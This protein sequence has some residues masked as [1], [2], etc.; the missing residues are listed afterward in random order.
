MADHGMIRAFESAS[1]RRP[2]RSFRIGVPVDQL[3]EV[4]I[5]DPS[6]LFPPG[7]RASGILL[8]ITSLP[9]RFGIGDFGPE[10]TRWIDSLALG[11]QSWWQ[12]LPIGPTSCGNSPYTP[13]STFAC[14]PLLISPERLIEDGLL[15]DE[16]C[17]HESFPNDHIRFQDAIPYKT[18]LLDKAWA[19]FHGGGFPE[20]ADDLRHFCRDQARW[21]DDFALFQVLKNRFDGAYYV[22]WPREFVTRDPAALAHVRE[23]SRD[24]IGRVK[25]EQFLCFRQLSQ[26]RQHAARRGVR[27]FGDIPI[28]VSADSADVW[29]NPTLF[30]LDQDRRPRFVAGV[31]PDY[32][33]ETGQLWGNPVYDW[34][35]MKQTA[36]RW[37]IDRLHSLLGHHDVIRLDHF[38]GFAAAWHVPAGAPTAETGEWIPGPGAD[39]FTE[40]RQQLGCLPFVAEDLG[41]ITDDVRELLAE[42]RFPRMS[43]LQFAFDGDDSNAF[44]PHN[45]VENMIAYTGTHDNDTS[46]GWY[47]SLPESGREFFWNYLG[48][49]P[50]PEAEVADILVD[51]A[52][53][54]PAAVA[55]APLQDLLNL[56]SRGRMN[57]PGI[58]DGNWAWRCTPEQLARL[59][60]ERLRQRTTS[61][62]RDLR[63]RAISAA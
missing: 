4:S 3:T 56:D 46:R 26:L 50:L 53:R 5:G 43:V 33:S 59:D 54:S 16:D 60:W 30:Q 28:F 2:T 24:A 48:T 57:T 15:R 40:L 22:H 61:Q 21:L 13:L 47:Q 8:H 6:C 11:G 29:A 51:L 35:A 14:N 1:P 20:L 19:R 63:R 62:G 18:E 49:E 45:M 9:S 23:T 55:I 10:A 31:P 34:A 12:I 17:P 7:Y 44:L 58:A 39:F 32:F 38:R 36:Y 37:W 27:L 25:W 42:F 41:T 52:W